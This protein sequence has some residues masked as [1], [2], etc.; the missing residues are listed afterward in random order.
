MDIF[1]FNHIVGVGDES[2]VKYFQ[3]ITCGANWAVEHT[4]CLSQ[5]AL[6]RA[7]HIFQKKTVTAFV[8]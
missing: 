8:N 5:P 1:E 6:F 4:R 2:V 3:E 7:T